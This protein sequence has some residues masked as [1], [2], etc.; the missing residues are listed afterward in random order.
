MFEFENR[1]L[2][3][4]EK[5]LEAMA[6]AMCATNIISTEKTLL[7]PLTIPQF[8]DELFIPEVFDPVVETIDGRKMHSYAVDMS[9]FEQQILPTGFPKT[10]VYGFGGFVRERQTGRCVYTRSSPGPTFEATRLQPIRVRY[11]NRLIKPHVFA[12]DPTLHWANPNNMPMEP[13]EPWP[14]FPPG[15]PAAQCPIPTITHLHGGETPAIYDGHPDAWFTAGGEHGSAF[16]STEMIYENTQPPTTLWYHDHA[17]GITRLNVVAGLAGLYLLRDSFSAQKYIGSPLDNWLPPKKYEIPLVIQDRIFNTDGSVYYP[18]V[19]TAPEV[20]PYWIPGYIG[21]CILV[22]GKVWPRLSVERRR[23]RFRLLNGS[24]ERIYRLSLSNGMPIT[25][26]GSDGGFLERPV[27][28]SALLIAPGER[29]DLLVDF[30][31]CSPGEQLLL[32]NDAPAPYPGGTPVDEATTARIM[33]FEVLEDGCNHPPAHLIPACLQPIPPLQQDAPSRIIVLNAQENSEDVVLMMTLNGLPWMAPV[34]ETPRVGA[35]E[36][37]YIVNL[38]GG[39]HPIHLHLIQFQII[40][41]QTMDT[42]AY[43]VKWQEL[44]GEPPLMQEPQSI[45]LEPYLTGSPEP[46][47]PYESGWKDT[48]IAQVGEVL[49]LRIR[50]APQSASL[51]QAKPGVN[52]F[53]FDP[54]AA[55]GYVWH[56]HIIDHEDNE[57]MRP[58]QLDC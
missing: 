4:F 29:Y 41:R 34:T 39:A 10:T 16:V 50:F 21:D 37:W 13:P 2:V 49:R 51:C 24:N 55:P 22:N 57:M 1:M 17:M 23:Y 14:L 9:E 5:K 6:S 33:R 46:P 11:V 56:C 8:T 15:F 32:R 28:T 45:P 40:S 3:L 27:E 36:D 31:S 43:Q 18:Q 30:S 52:L 44:N 26:I 47:A 48:A 20:H 35:T 54:C 19:G 38:L 12:V 7:N 58:L 53:P 25:V 42:D